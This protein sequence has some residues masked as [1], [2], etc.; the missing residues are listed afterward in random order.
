MAELSNNKHAKRNTL[1]DGAGVTRPDDSKLV[2]MPRPEE[3]GAVQEPP[4][5]FALPPALAGKVREA[6]EKYT[7]AQQLFNVTLNCLVEGYM[8]DKPP[9]PEGYIVNCDPS[10]GVIY[11]TPKEEAKPAE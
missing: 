6:W 5:P 10:H 2:K 3:R 7:S 4:H 11:F 9:V 1:T 8:A